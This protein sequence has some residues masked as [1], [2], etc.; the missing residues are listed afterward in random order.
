M[1]RTVD[2]LVGKNV[3]R[4]A[5]ATVQNPQP[6]SMENTTQD[7]LSSPRYQEETCIANSIAET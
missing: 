4:P 7:P 3:A 2:S 1:E 6:V 5:Q